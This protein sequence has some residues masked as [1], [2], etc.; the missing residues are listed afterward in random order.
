MHQKQQLISMIAEKVYKEAIGSDG[1]LRDKIKNDILYHLDEMEKEIYNSKTIF[2][3]DQNILR[4]LDWFLNKKSIIKD[5]ISKDPRFDWVVIQNEMDRLYKID[6]YLTGFNIQ[7]D[8]KESIK[9]NRALIKVN[10]FNKK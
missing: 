5:L 3:R 8:F 4:T 2:N 6:P 1:Y 10:L 9:K 7:F